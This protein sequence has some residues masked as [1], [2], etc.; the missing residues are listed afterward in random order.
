VA[1]SIALGASR[2]ALLNIMQ[3]VK[4]PI[5]PFSMS[6]TANAAY[7]VSLGCHTLFQHCQFFNAPNML[8][9]FSFHRWRHVQSM[10]NPTKIV[11]EKIQV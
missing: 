11:M 5:D 10:M 4:E 2:F 1:F 6:A 7:V 8:G 9:N 3:S